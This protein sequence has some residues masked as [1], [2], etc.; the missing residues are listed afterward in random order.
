ML[1]KGP[2]ARI[3]ILLAGCCL[4]LM[5]ASVVIGT[6]SI[7]L[8]QA[9]ADW[10]SD[11]SWR[12]SPTLSILFMHR[13][14]R[15]LAAILAGSGLA[16]AGCAFQALLRNPLATPYTLGV[17]SAGACGA[18]AATVVGS[19]LGLSLSFAG[20]SAVQVAA[21]AFAAFDVTV[22]YF[23]AV[24]RV[25]VAPSILLL[26]GIT[27]GMLANAGMMLLRYYAHPSEMY[28]MEHWLM[29]GVDVLGYGPIITLAVGVIPCAAVLLMQA[30]K[31]DQLGFGPE[32]AASRG[33]NVARLR[34]VTFLAGSLITAV[35]VSEVGPI[36]FVGLIVPHAVRGLTGSRHRTLM[37][38]TVL[39]GG[40]FLCFC[41]IIARKALPGET[42]IGIITA[43]LGGPF[44]LYLLLSRRFTEWDT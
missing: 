34:I 3:V 24:Q 13:L 32:I 7:S 23:M 1:G 42:P 15:T 43:F 28:R 44:F 4:F 36:G 38:L 18:Y 10:C 8:R 29:G 9:W 33:V 40:A 26:A 27:M 21:F 5:A 2:R 6:E 19:S 12:D 14:P 11:A 30:P 20:F 35:I 31:F 17:A 39:A 16:L 25:R 41:D 37:P 22:V